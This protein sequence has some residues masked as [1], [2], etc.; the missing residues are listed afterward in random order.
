MTGTRQLTE[1]ET[2]DTLIRVLEHVGGT[3]G[4]WKDRFTKEEL[5][6]VQTVQGA[7][8]RMMLNDLDLP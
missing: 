2:A 4:I 5:E 6:A 3:R 8:A 7:L 1:T